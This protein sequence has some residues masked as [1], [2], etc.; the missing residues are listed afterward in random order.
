MPHDPARVAEGTRA[1]RPSISR[2]VVD[3]LRVKLL[4]EPRQPVVK[5]AT[6]SLEA[7]DLYL[8]RSL[9]RRFEAERR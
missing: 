5:S 6:K 1:S 4:G 2:A 3:T 9:A 7:Y 8:Q